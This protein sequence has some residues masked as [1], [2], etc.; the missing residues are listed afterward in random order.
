ME[1]VTDAGLSGTKAL[2]VCP[3]AQNPGTANWHVQVRYETPIHNG[4]FYEISYS[5]KADAARTLGVAV[6]R[7]GGDYA[8]HFDAN[9]NLTV[10][11]QNFSYSYM[12]TVTDA[13]AKLKFYVGT[14]ASCVYIDNVSF[15]ELSNLTSIN[16]KPEPKEEDEWAVFPNPFDHQIM[17]ERQ[18]VSQSNVRY[19]IYSI[20]GLNAAQGVLNQQGVIALNHLKPGVY[21]LRLESGGQ[22]ETIKLLKQ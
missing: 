19:Q 18:I 1:V 7:D 11:A 2:K 22:F 12:S 8:T 15:V 13:T 5:A 9:E 3:D 21:F 10:D 14:N 17:V 16:D 4:K 6:Q 20:N